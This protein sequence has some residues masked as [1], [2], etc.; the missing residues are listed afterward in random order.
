[1]TEQTI[2]QGNLIIIQLSSINDIISMVVLVLLGI[3]TLIQILD[4]VGFIPKKWRYQL[5][6]NRS[7]DTIDVLKSLG[8]NFNQ[9]RKSN[10]TVG[11]PVDYSKE[12]VVEK[13]K[14]NL[15]TLKID[16]L[17]SVGTIRQT[18]L[19]YY[20]D[21]IGHSCDSTIAVAYARLLSSY[22]VDTIENTQLVK[23]PIIDFVVTPKDGSPILGYEFSKVIDKPFV[24]HE[25]SDRFRTEEDDMR[26]RF[27]CSQIPKKGC[28]ALIVDDSTTGGRL[29]LSVIDDLRKY[30][31]RVTDC[32]VVFEPQQKDARK[33][34]SDQ[35]V[36]LLSIVKTHD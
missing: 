9:Y 16:K 1:M 26:K 2:E 27:N 6:L 36:N 22:W 30:G 3:A 28:T 10:A 15:D 11:I 32:L 7:Q 17:V 12:T 5:K 25:L 14:K 33:K 34:L 20:I 18:E 19:N 23:S 21:L 8:I 4:M 24:L 13:T 31:Y 35:G 29:V